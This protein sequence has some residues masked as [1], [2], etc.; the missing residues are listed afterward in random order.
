VVQN[1]VNI[2]QNITNLTNNNIL[3][4]NNFGNESITH[5]TREFLDRCLEYHQKRIV[6][7]IDNIHFND[8]VPQNQNIK[9]IDQNS[10]GTYVNGL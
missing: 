5:L 3:V 6:N 9:L 4:L 1:P 8:E 7:V 10:I 2:T